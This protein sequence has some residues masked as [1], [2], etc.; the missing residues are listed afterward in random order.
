MHRAR[1]CHSTVRGVDH[2]VTATSS[3]SKKRGS[4]I[5]L[6]GVTHL[7]RNRIFP[8]K[9]SDIREDPEAPED[10]KTPCCVHFSLCFLQRRLWSEFLPFGLPPSQA[11]TLNPDL[12]LACKGIALFLAFLPT[13]LA[14]RRMPLLARTRDGTRHSRPFF[15]DWVFHVVTAFSSFFVSRES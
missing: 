10:Y 2:D 9:N 13:H 3:V 4:R 6:H 11:T 8:G 14:R 12:P 7:G 5:Y 1:M 15:D